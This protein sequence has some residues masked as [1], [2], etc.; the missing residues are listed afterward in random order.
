MIFTS[1]YN[2]AKITAVYQIRNLVNGKRYIGS[3]NGVEY[4]FYEHRKDLRKNQHTNLYLQN[5]WNKYGEASFAFEIIELCDKSELLTKEQSLIDSTKSADRKFGYNI[6][7]IADR[8]WMTQEVREKIS[9][10]LKGNV[11]WNLGKRHSEEA[12]EKMRKKKSYKDKH[13]MCGKHHSDETKEKIRIANRVWREKHGHQFL[14]K[15]HSE[16]AKKK[17]SEAKKGQKISDETK[18]KISEANTGR[19]HSAEALN[20]MK[21]NKQCK[22]VAQILNGEIINIFDS[23]SEAKRITGA[24][25]VSECALGKRKKS[26]GFQWKFV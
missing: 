14:G 16:D 24:K 11:P 26:G 2:A 12:K 3:S 18:R 10:S 25:N 4:R 21:H 20:K 19:R 13:P 9:K 15:H 7:E 8:P 23:V 22:R 5:A 6:C 1:Q 17:M